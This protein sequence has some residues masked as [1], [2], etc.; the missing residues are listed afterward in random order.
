MKH[1]TP[2][3]RARQTSGRFVEKN[4]EQVRL[5]GEALGRSLRYEELD[6]EA[7]RQAI[8]PYAP[9]DLLF[10]NWKKYI[11]TPAPITDTVERI[12]GKP[13]RSAAEWAAAYPAD[14]G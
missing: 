12:T 4:T 5:I 8:S 1:K 11:D 10:G 2:Q 13:P 14:H 7:A 6:L 9:A 3:H